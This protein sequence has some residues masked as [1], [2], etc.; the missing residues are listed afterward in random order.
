FKNR[1]EISNI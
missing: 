1:E